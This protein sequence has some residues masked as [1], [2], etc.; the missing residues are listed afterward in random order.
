MSHPVLG[1]TNVDAWV[2]S[3]PLLGRAVPGWVLQDTLDVLSGEPTSPVA[4][5]FYRA[6]ESSFARKAERARVSTPGSLSVGA[7]SLGEV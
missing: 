2:P 5:L 4:L 1:D 3:F 7:V 6:S